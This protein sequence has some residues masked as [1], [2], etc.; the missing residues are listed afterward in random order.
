MLEQF[1]VAAIRKMRV[2]ESLVR[3]A[4]LAW[5]TEDDWAKGPTLRR[6]S[7]KFL[8]E[9]RDADLRGLGWS[10]NPGGAKVARRA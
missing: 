6:W 4:V 7:D 2:E 1:R 5:Q 10:G 3:S 9:I 8:D